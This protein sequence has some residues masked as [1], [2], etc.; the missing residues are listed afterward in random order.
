MNYK[1]HKESDK[2]QHKVLVETPLKIQREIISFVSLASC[3]CFPLS[4]LYFYFFPSFT[5]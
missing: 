5:R 3:F 2:D 4:V 1:K